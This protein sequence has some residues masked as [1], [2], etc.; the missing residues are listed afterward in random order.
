[1]QVWLGVNA[2]DAAL[3]VCTPRG[4]GCIGRRS[5]QEV[6]DSKAAT[7]K[8]LR[9]V[10][11]KDVEGQLRDTGD[12]LAFAF[13]VTCKTKREGKIVTLEI[14]ADKT[15]FEVRAEFFDESDQ[16]YD[17]AIRKPPPRPLVR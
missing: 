5:D 10:F 9:G 2:F 4:W 17:E 13:D 7:L 11:R 15:R 14:K 12:E 8:V 1:M 3:R 16:S 6:Y